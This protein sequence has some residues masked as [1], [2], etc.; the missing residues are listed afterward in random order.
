M[1]IR[2][3]CLDENTVSYGV[4]RELLNES[5]TNHTVKRFLTSSL[6]VSDCSLLLLQVKIILKKRVSKR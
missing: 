5:Q 4:S 1:Y 6:L 2:F 3:V